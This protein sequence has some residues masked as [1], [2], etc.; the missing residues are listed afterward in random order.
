MRKRLETLL[1][2]WNKCD[3]YLVLIEEGTNAGF[4][5]INEARDFFLSVSKQ[6]EEESAFIFAPVFK[7]YYWSRIFLN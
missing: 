7:I 6:N 1:T 3:G 2:L 4:S 5:L